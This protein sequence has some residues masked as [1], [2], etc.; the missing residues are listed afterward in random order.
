MG[1]GYTCLNLRLPNNI[2]FIHFES[3]KPTYTY[4]EKM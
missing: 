2:Y 4:Y 1:I 3:N